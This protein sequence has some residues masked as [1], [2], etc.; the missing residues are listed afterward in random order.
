MLTAETDLL[1]TS[2]LHLTAQSCHF[3]LLALSFRF[4]AGDFIGH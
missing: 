1:A 3:C 4:Q 2:F